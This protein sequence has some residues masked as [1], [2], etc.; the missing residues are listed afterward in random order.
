MNKKLLGVFLIGIV[1]L[2][3]C[4][5][6]NKAFNSVA[7]NQVNAE[8]NQEIVGTHTLTPVASSVAQDAA[9]LAGPISPF[10]MPIISLILLGVNFFQKA[11]NGQLTSAI[12][13][14]VQTIENAGNDPTLAPAVAILKTQLATS[15]QIAGVQPIINNVLSDLKMLPTVP[16]APIAPI[17]PIAPAAPAGPVA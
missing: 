8:T 7:P 12:T 4:S 13:S 10:I 6:I 1:F 9:P 11:Q 3:G 14:T 2:V 15:H 16:V 5:A 17:A